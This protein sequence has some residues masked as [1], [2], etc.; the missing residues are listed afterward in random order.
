MEKEAAEDETV[1]QHH[2][3]SST[4]LNLRKLWKTVEYGGA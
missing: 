1:G 3:L 2:P 4:D